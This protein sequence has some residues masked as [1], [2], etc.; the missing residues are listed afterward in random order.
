[1]VTASSQSSQHYLGPFTPDL[2]TPVSQFG[3]VAK[4]K[5]WP[6]E[7][8]AALL[9]SCTNSSYEDLTRAASIVKQAQAQGLSPKCEFLVTPGSEQIRATMQRDGIQKV[10]ESIG[11]IILANACGYEK[12]YF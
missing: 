8:S 5:G 6:I 1:M 3:E 7:L 11:A 2:S 12:C 4:S 9:G 10:F